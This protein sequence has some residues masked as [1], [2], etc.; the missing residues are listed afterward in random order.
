MILWQ[1]SVD[2]NDCCPTFQQNN[3]GIKSKNYQITET[4][5]ILV[6][7]VTKIIAYKVDSNFGECLVWF[8]LLLCFETLFNPTTEKCE[9]WKLL[10]F[11]RTK[12]WTRAKMLNFGENRT[13]MFTTQKLFMPKCLIECVCNL[14]MLTIFNQTLSFA[15]TLEFRRKNHIRYCC[16][17]EVEF[18]VWSTPSS[19]PEK[20]PSSRHSSTTQ[21]RWFR[22]FKFVKNIEYLNTWN[23]VKRV[24]MKMHSCK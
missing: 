18:I 15:Q 13:C 22:F 5:G 1:K 7:S 19:R 3:T 4:L 12:M 16:W 17:K 21:I 10:G 2:V 8:S 24:L 20:L 9:F 23:S 6:F 14:I 11:C